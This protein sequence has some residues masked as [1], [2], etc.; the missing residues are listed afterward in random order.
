MHRRAGTLTEVPAEGS[1][2]FPLD[3]NQLARCSTKR[4]LPRLLISPVIVA[5]V[6]KPKRCKLHDSTRLL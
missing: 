3:D 2:K 1:C 4:K 5:G 6:G